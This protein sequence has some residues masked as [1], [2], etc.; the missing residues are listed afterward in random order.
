[1]PTFEYHCRPCQLSFDEL[2]VLQDDVKKFADSYPCP[3]CKQDAERNRVSSF[4][5]KFSGDV[6]GTSGV[7][8][9]SGVHDLDYPSLD[10]AVGRSSAKK[11][12]KARETQK[13]MAAARVSSETGAVA[14]DSSGKFVGISK[15]KLTQRESILSK[16]KTSE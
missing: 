10:K 7:H 12:E 8:G 15:E 5:F 1:M 13:E 16:A 14:Q 6:R 11:W 2:H 9:N 3:S 4:G